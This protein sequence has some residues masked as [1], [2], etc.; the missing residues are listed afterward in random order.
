M[1]DLD[2]TTRT[3]PRQAWVL[4]P[5][6]KPKEVTITQPYSSWGGASE[7]DLA[8]GGKHYHHTDLHPTKAAAI[9]AGREKLVAAQADVDKR[10]ATVTKRAAAL[11][12]A[13]GK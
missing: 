3:Y 10:Q 5:S 2:K 1:S 13:E 8:E 11:D 6:F 12:K 4:Q 9:A 7:W